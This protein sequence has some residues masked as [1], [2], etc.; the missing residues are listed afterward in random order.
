MTA[1][2]PESFQRPLAEF[3]DTPEAPRTA[4]EVLRRCLAIVSGYDLARGMLGDSN[5]G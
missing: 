3:T 4:D 2:A 5:A 1:K